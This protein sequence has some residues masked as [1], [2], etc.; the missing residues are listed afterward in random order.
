MSSSSE[1]TTV[2][3]L[4]LLRVIGRERVFDKARSTELLTVE[5]DDEEE[6]EEGEAFSA[7]DEDS[8]PDISTLK[9]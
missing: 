3:V 6:D 8:Q 7:L 5:D 1:C 9:G 4:L 2:E